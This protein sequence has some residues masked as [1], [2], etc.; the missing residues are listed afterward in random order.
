MRKK[1][2]LNHCSLFNKV[3][4]FV[5]EG[6][7]QFFYPKH[8]SCDFCQEDL[9]QE[10]RIDV[11]DKCMQDLPYNVKPCN[12]CSRPKTEDDC[13]ICRK[14]KHKFKKVFSPFVYEGDV[15]DAVICFKSKGYR[16]LGK[17]LAY[18]MI[19]TLKDANETFDCICCVPSSKG[20]IREK[21]YN[22]A[23]ILLK[24]MNKSL[25]LTDISNNL[26]IKKQTHQQKDLTINERYKEIKDKFGYN[27]ISKYSLKDKKV[28]VVD[29]IFTTGATMNEIARVLLIHG[30][31]SVCGIVCASVK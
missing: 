15:R 1:E 9:E 10:R 6:I 13:L 18:F 12:K 7:K 2:K 16:Y 5:Y 4:N 22:Q 3:S 14:Q 31:K 30:A 8:I 20:K 26:F 24:E 25:R 23:E 28:L 21:A 29:D 17:S 27:N 19:S 11:C